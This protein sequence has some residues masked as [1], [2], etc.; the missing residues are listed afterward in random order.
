M[1]RLGP[2]IYWLLI[3]IGGTEGPV[4]IRTGIVDL[5]GIPT[6][7]LSRGIVPPV[8]FQFTTGGS[9]KTCAALRATPAKIYLRRTTHTTCNVLPLVATPYTVVWLTGGMTSGMIAVIFRFVNNLCV[10]F[11]LVVSVAVHF[12]LFPSLV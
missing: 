3:L 7:F 5:G 2:S 10:E 11:P 6:V 1:D 4:Q 9:L 8:S 12:L